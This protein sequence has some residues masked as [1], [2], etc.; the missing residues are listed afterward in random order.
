MSGAAVLGELHAAARARRET[1]V[2]LEPLVER[3]V[4]PR[5][6][7]GLRG[8]V[9]LAQMVTERI[10]TASPFT[11]SRLEGRTRA[12]VQ[13]ERRGH[14][15]G[16]RGNRHT[17]LYSRRPPARQHSGTGAP[18]QVRGRRSGGTPRGVTAK[19]RCGGPCGRG[20][21]TDHPG[22]QSAMLGRSPAR[23][24]AIEEECWCTGES[25]SKSVVPLLRKSDRAEQAWGKPVAILALC[26]RPSRGEACCP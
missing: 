25:H 19:P 20:A 9:P 22:R 26:S 12:T 23:A 6:L 3:R 16:R 4:G 11:E 13:A 5:F 8:S 14:P 2:G 18:T 17:S 24:P 7:V 10:G 21:G 1:P 15:E